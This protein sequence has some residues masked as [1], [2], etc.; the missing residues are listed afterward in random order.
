[1]N[2]LLLAQV[3]SLTN[4]PEQVSD[5]IAWW[6]FVLPIAVVLFFGSWIVE[7]FKKK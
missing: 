3:R 5:A 7:K 4:L 2:S 6:K 1:M